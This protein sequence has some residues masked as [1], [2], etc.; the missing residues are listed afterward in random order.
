M[1]SLNATIDNL[2]AV[3]IV[4]LVLSL[5]VQ[6]V[7]SAVKKG[8]KMKSRQI[9]DSLAQLFK[10]AL[11]E[12]AV[13][14]DAASRAKATETT[15]FTQK[16]TPSSRLKR[17]RDILYQ[18]PVLRLITRRN[19]PAADPNAPQAAALYDAV[20]GRF[21]DIGRTAFSTRPI[22]DSLSKADLLGVLNSLKPQSIDPAFDAKLT[23]AAQAFTTLQQNF[24]NWETALDNFNPATIAGVLSDDDKAKLA[25]MQ[26]KVKPLLDD[27]HSLLTGAGVNVET[28]AGDVNKLRA[29]NL[30]DVQKIINDVRS[31]LAQALASA[32]VNKLTPAIDALTALDTGLKSFADGINAFRQKFDAVFANW[33]KVENSFDT[34]MQGFEER[35][36]RGMKTAALIISFLVVVVLNANFFTIYKDISTSDA[37]RT[38]ILQSQSQVEELY[39]NQREQQQQAAG[40]AADDAQKKSDNPVQIWFD[41]SKKEIDK[42]ASIFTGYGFSPLTWQGT[43]AWLHTLNPVEIPPGEKMTRWASGNFLLELKNDFKTLVGWLVMTL[44]LSVGAPFWQDF[45]ESLFGIKNVLRK[46]SDTQNVEQAAGAGQTKQS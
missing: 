9:E 22:F 13:T 1:I 40:A 34:V 3:V 36:A 37:K 6:S 20:V 21:R 8:L 10:I 4:L 18:S 15:A 14:S 41:T 38:L 43:K 25:E 27:L 46:K 7:Q 39:R 44:L 45:L 29:I 19:H 17:Y 30:D 23:T 33:K 2:I 5:V 35:Y 26:A 16:T 31:R 11:H 32:Q 28:L 42:N 24:R 12:V